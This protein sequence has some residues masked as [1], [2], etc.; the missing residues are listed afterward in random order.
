MA[1]SKE[2]RSIQEVEV[3]PIIRI[4]GTRG[5]G[6]VDDPTRAVEQYWDPDGRFLAEIDNYLALEISDA[7]S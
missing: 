7:S 1:K 3:V 2:F 6:T 4:K 5:K